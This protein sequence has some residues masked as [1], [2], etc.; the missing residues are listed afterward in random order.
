MKLLYKTCA[1]RYSFPT[2]LRFE[3]PEE[4]MGAALRRGGF[5]EVFKCKQSCGREIAVK[6]LLPCTYSGSQRMVDVGHRPTIPC[7]RCQPSTMLPEVLQGGHNLE[8][9]ATSEY[10]ATAG[11]GDDR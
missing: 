5:A 3:L 2:S 7:I 6:A 4:P 8:H 1:D 11:G 9:S 10:I